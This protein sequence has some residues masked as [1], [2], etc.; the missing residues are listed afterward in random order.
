MC[1]PCDVTSSCTEGGNEDNRERSSDDE[2]PV[3]STLPESVS[4]ECSYHAREGYEADP[5][6]VSPFASDESLGPYGVIDE[7][8]EAGSI[9]LADIEAVVL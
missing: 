8:S 7:H 9:V 1:S 2:V 5:R 6:P 4:K 3:G